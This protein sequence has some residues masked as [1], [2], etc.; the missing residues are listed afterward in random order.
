VI[1]ALLAAWGPG[2]GHP[3]DLDGDGIVG[4]MDFLLLLADWGP[5]SFFVDCN[6]NGVWDLIDLNNGTSPDCNSNAAP[7]E[8]DLADGTSQDCN[9]NDVPDECGEDCNGNGV[10]DECDVADGTSPDFNGN[11][12]PDECEPV[13]NDVCENATAIF[14]G[15]TPVVTGGATTEPFSATC[16]GGVEFF[17]N[18]IWFLYTAPCTGIATFSLCND[19]DFD[20]V[21][22]IYFA[23]NCPPPLNPLACSDNAV[24]CGQTSEI[25]QPVLEGIGYL[26]RVGGKEG[27][28]VGMLSV[29]CEP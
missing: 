26:V 6:G 24:G 16:E 21:L 3:A 27:A 2:P 5:C 20:T 29:S 15:A 22:A 13:P 18:D 4:N 23:E 28:G 11:G 7:D 10:A 9:G 14:D 19:A 8:C 12:I 17:V 25:Q 1:L